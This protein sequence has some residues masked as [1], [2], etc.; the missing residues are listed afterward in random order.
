MPARLKKNIKKISLKYIAVPLMKKG[1]P[2]KL[3]FMAVLPIHSISV[4]KLGGS[5]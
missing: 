5:P 3:E 4:G 2:Y 1:N